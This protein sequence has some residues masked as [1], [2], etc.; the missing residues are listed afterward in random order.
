MNSA[1]WS[2]SQVLE[3]ENLYNQSLVNSIKKL[4]HARSSLSDRNSSAGVTI[5]QTILD[6]Q[7][8]ISKADSEDLKVEIK[9]D[10]PEIEV[11]KEKPKKDKTKKKDKVDKIKTVK[12]I[13]KSILS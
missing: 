1:S 8:N 2:L 5:K 10:I 7:K 9:K 4:I 12:K 11:K 3:Q 13:S 6:A